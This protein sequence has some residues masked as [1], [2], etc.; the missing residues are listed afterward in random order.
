MRLSHCSN[1]LKV[2]VPESCI[3]EMKAKVLSEFAVSRAPL[4]LRQM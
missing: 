1:L 4:M 2:N 3:D